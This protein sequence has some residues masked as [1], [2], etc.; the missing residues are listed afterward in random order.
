MSLC[1]YICI[2][3][4]QLQFSKEIVS[5]KQYALEHGLGFSGFQINVFRIP[6]FLP[7]SK[8]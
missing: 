5:L 2:L 4:Q 8:Q 6:P 1:S 7:P 3:L